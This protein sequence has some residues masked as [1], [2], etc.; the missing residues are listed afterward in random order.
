MTKISKSFFLNPAGFFLIFH[1]FCVIV[2]RASGVVLRGVQNCRPAVE[3]W[4]MIRSEGDDSAPGRSGR[5]FFVKKTLL[6]RNLPFFTGIC[7]GAICPPPAV[8]GKTPRLYL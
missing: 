4:V 1:V 5:P 6:L 7:L 3:W 2:H 8:S